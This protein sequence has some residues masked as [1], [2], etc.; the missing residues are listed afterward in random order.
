[1]YPVIHRQTCSSCMFNNPIIFHGTDWKD[2]CDVFSKEVEHPKYC[3]DYV[4]VALS[5]IIP[6]PEGMLTMWFDKEDK[7][8]TV[9]RDGTILVDDRGEMWPMDDEHFLL[10]AVA[11]SITDHLSFQM[12]VEEFDVKEI[13]ISNELRG[14]HDIFKHLEYK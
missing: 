7:T 12:F 5:F 9:Y 1:M 4:P 11:D 3:K 14:R 10:D 6:T 13:K 2:I 8:L